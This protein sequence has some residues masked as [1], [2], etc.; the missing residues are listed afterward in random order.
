MT[1]YP[2][3]QKR[4]FDFVTPVKIHGDLGSPSVFALPYKEAAVLAGVG[5]LAEPE[6][7]APVLALNYLWKHLHHKEAGPCF[8]GKAAD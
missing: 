2:K 8:A 5:T 4:F 3:K 6:I 7:V 1:L